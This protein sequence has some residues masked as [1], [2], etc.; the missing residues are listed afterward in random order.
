M[1]N[2]PVA[3]REWHTRARVRILTETTSRS[4]D[5]YTVRTFHPGE[6]LEMV[7]WGREGRPVKRDAWWTSYDIDGAHIIKAEHVEIVEI[8]DEVAPESEA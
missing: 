4:V 8:L 6:E 7:Q 5:P 1:T 2:E 3:A